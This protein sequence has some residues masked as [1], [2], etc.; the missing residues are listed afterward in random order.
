[1]Y[2]LAIAINSL[3]YHQSQRL[4]LDK[5]C[6]RNISHVD[7]LWHV[8]KMAVLRIPR[9]G[10]LFDPTP[11]RHDLSM[12]SNIDMPVHTTLQPND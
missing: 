6:P 8:C 9:I 3:L 7:P 4:V 2:K 1:M 5:L 11:E 10:S 12:P